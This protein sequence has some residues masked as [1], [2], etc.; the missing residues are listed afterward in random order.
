MKVKVWL[1]GIAL[2]SFASLQAGSEGMFEKLITALKE[3]R[4]LVVREKNA[5]ADSCSDVWE[6]RQERLKPMA[7]WGTLKTYKMEILSSFISAL[8]T[9]LL[10]EEAAD[11]V[12]KTSKSDESTSWPWYL[13]PAF[14]GAH[15]GNDVCISFD[16]ACILSGL[17]GLTAGSI[18]FLL[19]SLK[20]L[21]TKGTENTDHKKNFRRALKQA[22]LFV[23]ATGLGCCITS[24]L[25]G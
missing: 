5:F 17:V 2:M 14:Y 19:S 4:E 1:A 25:N 8:V 7:L 22:L 11:M 13:F 15:L 23:S 6:N 16:D 21:K 12:I 20:S 9:G 24:V 3:K 18:T 10:L